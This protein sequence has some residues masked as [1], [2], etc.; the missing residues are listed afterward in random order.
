M[1]IKYKA[2]YFPAVCIFNSFEALAAAG[3]KAAVGRQA[4]IRTGQVGRPTDNLL[5]TS[6][7]TVK[8]TESQ[9]NSCNPACQTL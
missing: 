1:T 7:R 8:L 6:K 5:N 4:G 9:T 3:P 2:F